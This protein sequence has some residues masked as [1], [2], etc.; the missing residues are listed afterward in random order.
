MIYIMNVHH[1]TDFWVD[2]QHRYFKKY[3]DQPYRVVSFMDRVPADVLEKNKSKFF[4]LS[5]S[6]VVAGDYKYC[7]HHLKMDAL[8]ELVREWAEPDD[9]LLFTDSD[10]FP[11]DNIDFYIKK[12]EEY[13]LL[14][15]QRIE[16]AGDKCPHCMFSLT[17][18]GFWDRIKGSW[19]AGKTYNDFLPGREDGGGFLLEKLIASN[20]NWY[21]IRR[22]NSSQAPGDTLFEIYE[23]RIYH[24]GAGSRWPFSIAASKY[25]QD[26]NLEIKDVVDGREV[27]S[28]KVKEAMVDDF[29]FYQNFMN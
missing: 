5:S 16:N 24:H 10:S 29:Y 27:L 3:I 1:E 2:I 14:A 26:N 11:I 22:S 7:N 20:E 13:P 18:M 9:L 28:N 12:L 23:D 21:M 25:A 6:N 17:T 8:V 4:H 19:K 15:V